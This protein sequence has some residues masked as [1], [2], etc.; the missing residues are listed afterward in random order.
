MDSPVLIKVIG[1]SDIERHALNSLLRISQQRNPSFDL[2]TA[3]A[4]ASPT[5][6]LIDGRMVQAD[7]ETLQATAMHP[8]ARV[9][10]FGA[11]PPVQ[12][13]RVFDRPIPWVRVLDALDKA[14]ALSALGQGLAHTSAQEAS[15]SAGT[16]ASSTNA[17]PHQAQA[18]FMDTAPA[19]PQLQDTL[20]QDTQPV[21]TGAVQGKKILIADDDLT[22]RLYMRAK[23]AS[24]NYTQ[25]DEASSGQEALQMALQSHYDAIFLDIDMPPGNG[26]EVC[27]AIKRQARLEAFSSASH[28]ANKQRSSQAKVILVTSRDG[29][30]DRVRGNLVGADAYV[31]K[32]PLPARLSE[33]IQM[34]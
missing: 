2:W 12:A 29:I 11:Y 18:D 16:N 5:A 4:T 8:R 1:F 7:S 25:V 17:T 27:R 15:S 24:L 32:P 33:I 26:F 3:A 31:T 6:L 19:E 23:L 13:W 21:N 22:C 20:L 30:I 14:H 10:W 34:L 9:L 28:A